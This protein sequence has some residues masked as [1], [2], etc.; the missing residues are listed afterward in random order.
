MITENGMG[1]ENGA[2][3][4]DGVTR[5][6]L[7]RDTLYWVQRARADHVPVIGYL[8]WGLTDSYE[9]GS[10]RPRFGLYRVDV[11]NDPKLRRR[12]TAAVPVFRGLIRGRGVPAGYRL[13]QRPL[14]ADCATESVR[15]AD[16]AACRGAVAP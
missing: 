2:R 8:Y 11:N 4:A 6:R 3:R 13:T 7:L 12:P 5:Q 9:W 15:D 16:R 10:Y 14:A 1:T